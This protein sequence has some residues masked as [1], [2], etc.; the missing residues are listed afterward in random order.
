MKR[1][2]IPFMLGQAVVL[3]VISL[4]AAF[5]INIYNGTP[6]L[7]KVALG[8]SV[9]MF[10]FVGM[11]YVIVLSSIITDR[12]VEKTLEKGSEEHN[13]RDYSTFY[14]SGATIRIEENTG[15]IAYVSNQNPFE[16]Q[17]ISAK[18]I[19]HIRSSYM[20]GPLG[21]T[22][23]VYFEFF[24]NKKRTRVPTFTSNQAYSMQSSEVLTAISKADAYC[25]IL[26]NAKNSAR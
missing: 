19:S 9:I 21:G 10:F 25:E 8:V 14:S 17:V 26:E 2:S 22:S 5:A 15:K 7:V 4:I 13:F 11:F 23:Y 16:F 3:Y 20:K 24:Y 6:D 12:M 18:D 1:F